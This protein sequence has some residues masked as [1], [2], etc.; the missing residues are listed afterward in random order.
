MNTRRFKRYNPETNKATLLQGGLV[1]LQLSIQGTRNE[2]MSLK[3]L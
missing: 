2:Y 1:D 3:R